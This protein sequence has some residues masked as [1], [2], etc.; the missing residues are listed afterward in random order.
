MLGFSSI[1]RGL[2]EISETQTAIIEDSEKMGESLVS[3]FSLLEKITVPKAASEL[4]TFFD[5]GKAAIAGFEDTIVNFV[6]TGTFSF[7]EFSRSLIAEMTRIAISMQITLPLMQAWGAFLSGGGLGQA[8]LLGS[9]LRG[10]GKILGF[11]DGGIIDEPVAGI[12]LRTGNAYTIGERGPEAIVPLSGT[13][14][15]SV[16][17]VDSYPSAPSTASTGDGLGQEDKQDAST[18]ST[19]NN[20]S[21]VFNISISAV[22]SDSLVRLMRSNPEAITAPL[23]DALNM[24]DRGMINSIRNAM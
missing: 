10:T 24:G 4:I 16:D 13:G 20:E 15:P 19:Q 22:D 1:G 18:Y 2:D 23:A 17:K 12:G 7:K 14:F 3:T 11:A 8:G 9:F 5:I 21:N 6:R